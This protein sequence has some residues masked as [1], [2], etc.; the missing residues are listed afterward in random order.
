MALFET[1]K[2]APA[3]AEAKKT[4]TESTRSFDHVLI[5]PRITEKS[6]FSAE[7]NVY[8]FDIA[9]NATKIDVKAAMQAAYKVTPVKVSITKV[10]S[11][12]VFYRGK[13][14][15]KSAGKK[16]YVYLDKK[17]KIELL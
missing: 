16:A 1:K 12:K 5:A 13:R 17:D 14:G 6:T 11:R 2:A 7:D 9:T 8:V 4:V 10:P 15:V 3:K